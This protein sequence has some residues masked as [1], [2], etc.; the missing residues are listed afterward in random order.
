MGLEDKHFNS[1]IDSSVF[2]KATTGQVVECLCEYFLQPTLK[3][4]AWQAE[5]QMGDKKSS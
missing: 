2:A 4:S 5:R 1:N 3:T